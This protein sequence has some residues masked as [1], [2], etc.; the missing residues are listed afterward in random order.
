[1]GLMNECR[2]YVGKRVLIEP[3]YGW[4]GHSVPRA[5]SI[6]TTTLKELAHFMR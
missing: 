1:M 4:G 2:E 5:L 3:M 6:P